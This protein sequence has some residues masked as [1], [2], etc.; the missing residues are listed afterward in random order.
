VLVAIGMHLDLGRPRDIV[1]SFSTHFWYFDAQG[2]NMSVE[3]T[4]VKKINASHVAIILDQVQAQST[5]IAKIQNSLIVVLESKKHI[6][7][8]WI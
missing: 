4:C 7:S 5:A 1:C 3:Y 6:R 8:S 2:N